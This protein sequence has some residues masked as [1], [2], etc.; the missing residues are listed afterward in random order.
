M[1]LAQYVK[2]GAFVGA[3][4]DQVGMDV[5]QRRLDVT[6][7]AADPGG[8][9]RSGGLGPPGARLTPD[10]PRPGDGAALPA[11][12]GAGEVAAAVTTWLAAVRRAA[13]TR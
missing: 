12:R 1:K 3:V 9:R 5:V 8:D 11:D 10:M 4:V 6:G 13:R 7:D 2:G